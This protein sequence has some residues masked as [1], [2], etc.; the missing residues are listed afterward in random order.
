MRDSMWNSH[1]VFLCNLNTICIPGKKKFLI[2]LQ[3]FKSFKFLGI[4]PMSC[5]KPLSVKIQ[6]QFHHPRGSLVPRCS[7][8]FPDPQ[9]PGDH[10][11]VFW[12]C[13]FAVSR[14]SYYWHEYSVYALCGCPLSLRIMFLGFI[15]VVAVICSLV[16]LNSIPLCGCTTIFFPFIS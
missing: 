14:R 10:S 1:S 11:L 5:D 15:H 2:D 6:K 4:Q 7:C 13:S 16:L 3:Y 9:S 8:S 12:P